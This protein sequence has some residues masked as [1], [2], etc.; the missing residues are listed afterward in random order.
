MEAIN[1]EE[2]EMI[3]LT[4]KEIKSYE[5]QEVCH[6]CKEEFC[7]DKNEENEFKLY[8]KVRYHC[9]YTGKFR[10]AAHSICNL[11]HKVPKKIPVIFHNVTYDPHFIIKQLAEE[12]KDQFT[13]LGENTEKYITFSVTI[14]KNMIMVKQLHID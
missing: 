5:E 14:K 1:Y 10:G 3:P 12:F 4:D 7:F 2:K 11:K 6:I 8:H 13:C 9:H